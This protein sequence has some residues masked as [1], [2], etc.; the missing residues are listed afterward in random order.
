MIAPCAR[1]ASSTAAPWCRRSVGRRSVGGGKGG[2][3]GGRGWWGGDAECGIA[4]IYTIHSSP[5][6]GPDAHA[7]YGY[8]WT[9]RGVAPPI[10]QPI[11]PP[12][13]APMSVLL[14][15]WLAQGCPLQREDFADPRS[16]PTRAPVPT[17]TRVPRRPWFPRTHASWIQ[18][19]G[20]VSSGADWPRVGPRTTAPPS[21][22]NSGPTSLPRR[23]SRDVEGSRRA[24]V[25]TRTRAPGVAPR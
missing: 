12:A 8:R 22:R 6:S 5:C 17:P 13:T 18:G 4:V 24:Y 7:S 21:H 23:I 15:S 19:S 11:A 20:I 3:D 14:N 10:N 2:A 16:T 25:R 1:L 9:Q